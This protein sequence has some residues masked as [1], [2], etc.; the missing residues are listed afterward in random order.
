MLDSL[1][2]GFVHENTTSM[3]ASSVLE[4]NKAVL[5]RR[6]NN[7]LPAAAEQDG[8]LLLSRTLASLQPAGGEEDRSRFPARPDDSYMLGRGG[9]P[10]REETGRKAQRLTRSGSPGELEVW[11]GVCLARNAL[12]GALAT[13]N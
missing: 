3:A 13:K 10:V 11:G 9:G 1:C 7:F 5:R 12:Q 4:K 8:H 6:R 2:S